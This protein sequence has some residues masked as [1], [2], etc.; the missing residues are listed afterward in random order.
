MASAASV[1]LAAAVSNAGGLGIIGS[2]SMK[3]DILE[4]HII[5]CKQHTDK[6]FAVNIAIIFAVYAK[7]QI[8]LIIKH[9]VPI[10]FTSAGNPSLYTDLL[11]SNGI[12]VVHV[13]SSL[14]FALKA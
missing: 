13:V 1:E 5:K 4:E 8:E 3:P 2:A 11:K 10:V 12:K 14:K 6:P 7:P 9:K